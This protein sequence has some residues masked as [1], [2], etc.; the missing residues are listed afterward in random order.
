MFTAIIHNW[1]WKQPKYPLTNNGKGRCSIYTM[2]Y[3]LATN[4]WNK[5]HRE[6]QIVYAFTSIWASKKNKTN[7]Q[8]K[9]NKTNKKTE[10]TQIQETKCWFQRLGDGGSGKMLFKGYTLPV[11]RWI[12]SGDLMYSMVIAVNRMVIYMDVAETIDLKC[13]H[14][15]KRNNYV[16]Y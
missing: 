3:C 7:E 13:S 1:Q 10:N 2:E 12:S 14:H 5:S 4:K 16:T 15:K 9:Q 6:R 8:T 11:I